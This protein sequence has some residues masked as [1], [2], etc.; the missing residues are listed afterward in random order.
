MSRMHIRFIVFLIAV[1]L[2]PALMSAQ[3]GDTL[4]A[5]RQQFYLFLEP[6][7]VFQAMQPVRQSDHYPP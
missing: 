3:Q 5:L 4:G 6:P 2:A 1:L 7:Q